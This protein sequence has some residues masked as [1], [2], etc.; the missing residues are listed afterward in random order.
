M[1]CWLQRRDVEPGPEWLL[2]TRL[3]CD[4]AATTARPI[5]GDARVEW[6]RK[7]ASYQMHL[8]TSVGPSFAPLLR[9]RASSYVGCSP[10]RGI[11]PQ[12]YE[13]ETRV[14]L[15]SPRRLNVLFQGDRVQLANGNNEPLLPGAR[16]RPA[17]SCS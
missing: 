1:R 12:R 13:E 6:L 2:S 17:S 15:G 16:T 14:A 10:P 5:Y 9:R 3:E 7:G 8:E 11:R 4:P